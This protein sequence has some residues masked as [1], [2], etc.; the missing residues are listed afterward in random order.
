[1]DGTA[2]TETDD[3]PGDDRAEALAAWLSRARRRIDP[4]FPPAIEALWEAD[5]TAERIRALKLATGTA[6]VT[7]IVTLPLLWFLL[8]DAH[9]SIRVLWI[10]G[11]IPIGL[12]S[13][14]LLWT[15]QR[16]AAQEWQITASGLAVGALFTLLMA[17][18]RYGQESLYFGTIV[19]LIMLDAVAGRLCFRPTIVLVGGLTAIFTAGI[20]NI[21]LMEDLPGLALIL[22]LAMTAVF[23][24]FGN[25][26]LETETR[27][28]FALA[29]RE[30]LARQELSLRT[31]ELAQLAGR[32]PL[33]GLANRRT[34]DAWLRVHWASLMDSG[35]ALG[36]IVIDVDYFKAYN[37]H[38]GHAAGDICLQTIA[39]CLR[40]QSR[41]TT[42]QVA[43]IGGEEFA[44]L[45]PGLK[46]DRCGD[47][48]E[49]LRVGIAVADLPNI[50][51]PPPRRIT[52]S[53]GAASFQAGPGLSQ[54]DLFAAADAA[55]YAA[56]QAGRNRVCLADQ[57]PARNDAPTLATTPRHAQSG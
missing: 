40:E 19:T 52:I 25:W 18:S 55:L 1:M 9:A 20:L 14:V 32:D 31:S 57:P 6:C 2:L 41:G 15:N 46:L 27:R 35:A 45:L 3:P 50:G 22:L 8:P 53:C 5:S 51:A 49:R 13:H 43:R 16:V 4:R 34:Y 36:L 38:Y 7:A 12:V 30:R 29:L 10:F 54:A 47:I 44:V 42:D 37:D 26:R 39:R 33:T 24:L 23:A 21:P 11:G 28:S 48:A 56:K 17:T